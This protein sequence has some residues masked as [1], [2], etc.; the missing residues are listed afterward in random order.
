[1]YADDTSAIISAENAIELQDKC[2]E[3][4]GKVLGWFQANKLALNLKKTKFM[5]FSNG[6]RPSPRINLSVNILNSTVS[7]DQVPNQAEHTIRLLGFWF[8]EKLTINDHFMK[9][10]AKIS[11]F[12]FFMRGV[13]KSLSLEARKLLYFAH[14]HSHLMYCIPLF[15]LSNQTEL[16]KL[17]KLQKKSI[18]DHL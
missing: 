3:E 1:M 2:N 14:I 16:D 15:I 4:F 6:L 7:L 12:L 8:N 17:L 10:K 13:R 9:V 11:R 5:V 18:A